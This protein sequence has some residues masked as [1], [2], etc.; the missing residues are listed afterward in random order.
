[1]EFKRN[2]TDYTLQEFKDLIGAI[3]DAK[4][5]EARNELVEHFNQIVPHPAG[6]DLLFYPEDEADDSPGGVVKIIEDYCV[7]KGLPGFKDS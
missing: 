2:L 4:T 5:E 3:D 6:S 1:M 7:S